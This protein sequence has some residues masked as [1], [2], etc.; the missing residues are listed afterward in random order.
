MRTTC[1]CGL[2]GGGE[3]GGYGSSG[4]IPFWEG[5]GG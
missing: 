1:F 3:G 5:G 2:G 4:P